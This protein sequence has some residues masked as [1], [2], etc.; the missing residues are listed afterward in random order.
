MEKTLSP[1]T[2]QWVFDTVTFQRC[3]VRVVPA[4][5]KLVPLNLQFQWI[6]RARRRVFC[7]Q[8]VCISFQTTRDSAEPLEL[9]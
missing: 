3:Q 9:I 4:S 8:G 1:I 5:D 2:E 6:Y 7:P